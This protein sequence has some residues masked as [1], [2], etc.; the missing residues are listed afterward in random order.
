[1]EATTQ[2]PILCTTRQQMFVDMQSHAEKTITCHCLTLA[3]NTHLVTAPRLMKW[4]IPNHRTHTH[5]QRHTAGLD[6]H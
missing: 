5:D 3:L 4:M 2:G 1:M 6:R